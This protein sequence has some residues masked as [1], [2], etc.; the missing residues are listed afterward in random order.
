[1][2]TLK[3]VCNMEII[4]NMAAESER[5]KTLQPI[6]DHYNLQPG[7]TTYGEDA[8]S[9][10]Y[11]SKFNAKLHQISLTINHIVL[12]EKYRE[13]NK[14]LLLFESDVLCLEDF[15][16]TDIKLH[17]IIKDME[18]HSIDFV[19]L[20][21]GCFPS[22]DTRTLK[23]V[24]NNLYKTNTSRCTESHIISPAG[25]KKFLEYF[26]STNN[27]TVIDTN[28]NIFFKAHPE[29]FCCWAIPELF[30]QG[31]ISGMYSSLIPRD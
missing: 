8:K 27:H 20:G 22:V 29:V 6:I 1:M 25:I 21:K 2:T 7:Y 31:S 3:D 15:I 30:M 28:Y 11:Y 16:A 10:P 23:H 19:F 5:L 26:Y 17:N 14:P 24:T 13:S 18:T 4:C 12:M 9:H